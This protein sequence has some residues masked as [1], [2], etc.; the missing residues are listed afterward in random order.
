MFLWFIN[1]ARVWS[2]EKHTSLGF[3]I[4]SLFPPGS[5]H[6]SC[7]VVMSLQY[8]SGQGKYFTWNDRRASLLKGQ[9]PSLSFL[10][11]PE[12][13][14]YICFYYFI[15]CASGLVPAVKFADGNTGFGWSNSLTGETCRAVV[16]MPAL[17]LATNPVC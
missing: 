1:T 13:F 2:L 15:L 8:L 17:A 9:L 4:L 6:C 10:L 14:C 3:P 11:L 5:R 12:Y 7:L 16:A